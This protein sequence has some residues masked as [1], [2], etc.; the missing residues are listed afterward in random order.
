MHIP[1]ILDVLVS[2]QLAPD[3][4]FCLKELGDG[5]LPYLPTQVIVH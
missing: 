1:K 3:R 2:G 5:R 4:E